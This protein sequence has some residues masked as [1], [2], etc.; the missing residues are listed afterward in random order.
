[1]RVMYSSDKLEFSVDI[2]TYDGCCGIGNFSRMSVNHVKVKNQKELA[3]E[4][5]KAF[6]QFIDDMLDCGATYGMLTCTDVTPESYGSSGA[7]YDYDYRRDHEM[8]LYT[9]ATA[10]KFRK[11]RTCFNPNTDNDIVLFSKEISYAG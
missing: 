10:N 1:M 2:R 9:F 11:A 5:R 7:F 4:C 3:S 6:T 8:N